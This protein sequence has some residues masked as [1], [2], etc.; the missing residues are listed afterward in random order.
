MD[1]A[2]Y[3]LRTRPQCD[4]L[5]AGNLDK[6]GFEVFLPK[7][8]VP[9]PGGRQERV[10]L[11]PG[12]LFIKLKSD[13]E[14]WPVITLVPGVLGWVRMDGD[15]PSVPDEL[16]NELM[17]RVRTINEGGGLWTRFRAGQTVRVVFGKMDGLAKVVE[18]PRTPESR[19]KVM[20]ELMGRQ[21]PSEVPWHSIRTSDTELEAA[22]RSRR[23]RRTRGR[24]RWIRGF[25]PAP[26]VSV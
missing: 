14:N 8:R 21:V 12:Y 11:F 9:R 5:A 26:A 19:V 22:P 4:N 3:V 2:W 10:P 6:Q 13:D 25:G 23:P 1:S 15:V 16:V 17:Q 7:V 20:L 24:G 18:E